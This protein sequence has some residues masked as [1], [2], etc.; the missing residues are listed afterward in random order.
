MR[1][2]NIFFTVFINEIYIYSGTLP[3]STYV[4]TFSKF[5]MT[6]FCKIYR[7]FLII[8]S[9]GFLNV[10][11]K[12]FVELVLFSSFLENNVRVGRFHI[13]NCDH[14]FIYKISIT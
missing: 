4:T 11:Q 6:R 9:C 13:T 2:N 1:T 3:V 10:N 7:Y 5:F 8:F 14:S 12:S